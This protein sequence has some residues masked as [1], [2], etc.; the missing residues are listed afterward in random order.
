[1]IPGAGHCGANKDLYSPLFSWVEQGQ[2][3][4][5]VNVTNIGQGARDRPVWPHPS[6]TVYNPATDSFVQGG[7]SP[8]SDRFDWLGL[9]HYTPSHTEWCT[10]EGSSKPNSANANNNA[11]KQ[12]WAMTCSNNRPLGQ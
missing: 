11:K 9:S 4:G 2:T 10:I 8:N 1:M 7:P 5:Q 3:P 6:L 12:A